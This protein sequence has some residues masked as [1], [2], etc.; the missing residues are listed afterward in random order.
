MLYE[1][2][3]LGPH[4]LFWAVW[5]GVIHSEH[6][7]VHSKSHHDLLWSPFRGLVANRVIRHLVANQVVRHLV[8]NPVIGHQCLDCR[9]NRWRAMELLFDFF[10]C[11]GIGQCAH[12]LCGSAFESGDWRHNHL[13]GPV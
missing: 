13:I 9:K 4:E 7:R 11:L 5:D 3:V 8:T 2:T 12:W 10:S 6:A 1:H